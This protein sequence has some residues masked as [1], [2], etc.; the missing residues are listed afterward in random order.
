M[1]GLLANRGE[2]LSIGGEFLRRLDDRRSS[3]TKREECMATGLR[4]VRESKLAMSQ[5][6]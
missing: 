4:T 1:S 3:S 2:G 6:V 5:A